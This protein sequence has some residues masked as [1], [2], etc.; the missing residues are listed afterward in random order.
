LVLSAAC[1]GSNK[2]GDKSLLNFKDQ[3]QQ[4]LG[5][6]TTTTAAGGGG[7]ATTSTAKTATT[8]ARQATAT[9]AHS[10]STVHTT[11]TV[12]INGDNSASAFDPTELKVAVGTTVVWSNRDAVA[13]SVKSDDGK[14]FVSPTIPPG[15]SWTYTATTAGQFNYHD[16]SRPYAVASLEVVR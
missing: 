3:S 14:T 16:G 15:G 10:T 5:Q 8:A 2:V 12:T 13:R 7:G 4:Q 9:T 6:S 11:E 1:G